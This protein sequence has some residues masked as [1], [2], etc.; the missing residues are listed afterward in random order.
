MAYCKLCIY[1]HPVNSNFTIWNIKHKDK[2]N[3]LFD[4]CLILQHATFRTTAYVQLVQIRMTSSVHDAKIKHQLHSILFT[5]RLQTKK[6]VT[7]IRCYNHNFCSVS[8]CMSVCFSLSLKKYKT[9]DIILFSNSYLFLERKL[10]LAWNV[11]WSLG[12]ELYL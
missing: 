5:G 3:L 1:T 7:V 10:V 8:V 12:K 4:A 6:L 11:R 2:L 9:W